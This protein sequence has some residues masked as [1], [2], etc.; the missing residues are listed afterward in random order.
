MPTSRTSGLSFIRGLPSR[1]GFLSKTILKLNNYKLNPALNLG[2]SEQHILKN[3]SEHY[4]P[5]LFESLKYKLKK[6]NFRLTVKLSLKIK[7]VV[8]P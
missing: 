1:N 7:Y 4:I 3:V 8:K 5:G 2:D 6:L